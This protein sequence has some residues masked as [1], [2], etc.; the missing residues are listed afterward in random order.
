MRKH[1][2][3]V[4]L[5]EEMGV[6]TALVYNCL[7]DLCQEQSK[8]NANYHNGLFWVRMPMRDLLRIFPYMGKDTITRAIKKLKAEGLVMVAHYDVTNG[9]ANWYA[10]T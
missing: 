8:R 7:L 10:T 5:A 9:G 1:S 3:D 6:P 4:E 2:F